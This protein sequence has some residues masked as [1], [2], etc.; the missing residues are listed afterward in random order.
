MRGV[1]EH[2]C[3]VS[4]A[5]FVEAVDEGVAGSFFDEAAEGCFWH[6]GDGANFLEGDLSVEVFVHEF[7]HFFDAAT[8]IIEVATIEGGV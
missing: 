8:V 4:E 3:G 2:A 1:D 7:K 6:V 5:D